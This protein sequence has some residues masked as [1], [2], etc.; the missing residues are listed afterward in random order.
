MLPNKTLIVPTLLR[1]NAP[2]DA[3]ASRFPS[4]EYLIRANLP[5][6]TFLPFKGRE[7]SPAESALNPTPGKAAEIAGSFTALAGI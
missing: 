4:W 6:F 1:G 5:Q 7:F 3:P 2:G